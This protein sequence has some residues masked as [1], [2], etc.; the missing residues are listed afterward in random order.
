MVEKSWTLE[1]NLLGRDSL[2][3]LYR[4]DSRKAIAFWNDSN[5]KTNKS[6]RNIA[7]ILV[8]ISSHGLVDYCLS[9]GKN[10]IGLSVPLSPIQ[11]N[12]ATMAQEVERFDCFCELRNTRESFWTHKLQPKVVAN[13]NGVK[14]LLISRDKANLTWPIRNKSQL[15]FL[16]KTDLFKGKIPNLCHLDFVL[17]DTEGKPVIVFSTMEMLKMVDMKTYAYSDGKMM[18][19]EAK[20]AEFNIE[21]ELF[22]E[23]PDDLVFIRHFELVLFDLEQLFTRK[24]LKSKTNHNLNQ[25]MAAY[26][27]LMN[28]SEEKKTTKQKSS[29]KN[30]LKDDEPW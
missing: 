19:M 12:F 18:K 28:E 8:N 26:L 23:Q 3:S 29:K 13:G 14:L 25:E 5:G 11:S 4:I 22:Y 10:I 15:E 27:E 30:L 1:D 20:S 9:S 24:E 16:W 17:I 7:F 6:S 2:I 21:L